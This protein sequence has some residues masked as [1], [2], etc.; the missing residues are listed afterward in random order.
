MKKTLLLGVLLLCALLA[1]AQ[2]KVAP[3]LV[4][5][6]KK[7]YTAESIINVAG[8]KELK[9][10]SV[11]EISV[12]DQLADGYV[13]ELV[14]KKVE[15]NTEADLVGRLMAVSEE[16]TVNVPMRVQTDK[17]GHVLKMLN[18]SEVQQKTQA[19]ISKIVDE[20][21]D[22]YP[23]AAMVSK[24]KIVEQ[25]K[26]AISEKTLLSGF[27]A[28]TNP[29]VLNGKTI[30]MG[31][32]EE[33]VNELGLKMKRMFFPAADGTITATST[34]NTSKD[35]IKQMIIQQV[36]RLAPEQAEMVKQNIDMLIQSGAA[37][38]EIT[39][40][41]VYTLNADG[42]LKSITAESERN[43]MGQKSSQKTTVTLQ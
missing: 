8:Q 28:G 12:I 24:D 11:G 38:F 1:G 26:T 16:L 2:T 34:M 23:A 27:N 43:A 7:T 4:K 10:S 6:D 31:A 18:F 30:S 41:A 36:E 42:W 33:Y 25:L 9:M 15:S 13:L 29:L 21:I 17:D 35:D 32:Q 3:K 14:T 37:K 20:L 22:Q 19:A 5:G 39:E 40:K